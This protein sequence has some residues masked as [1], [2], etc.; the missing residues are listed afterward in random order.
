MTPVP[1]LA[2]NGPTAS[3]KTAVAV[4]VA[5]ALASEGIPAEIVNADSM[6]V[7]RG[8]NIGTAKPTQAERGGVPHHLIDIMDV[9]Q[10]ASVADFQQL[11]RAVIAE[12]S[13][14]GVVPIL[15]GG[16][17]LYVHAIVD[18]FRFPGTD[19]ELRA[20][21]EA[22]LAELGPAALHER[23][24]RLAPEAAAGILPGNGRR[25]V[26]ALEV[27]ELTGGFRSQLPEWSYAL[28]DVVQ[29]GLEVARDVLDARIEERVERMW[30]DGLV[31]EVVGL[32]DRGLRKGRTASR[33]IGYRQ[34]L[35]QL[36]GEL[37][38]A[39][40]KQQ[41][42]FGTRRLARKQL[43]WF[44]RDPRI[45]W[46]PAGPDAVQRIVAVVRGRVERIGG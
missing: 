40:A 42:V 10:D 17:A 45:E 21:L 6:L 31:A 38:E 2:L 29:V 19:P 15:A 24:I 11:A 41:T 20:R 39:Q 32:V 23:L 3:G 27:V 34:V 43:G 36:D 28:D 9:T 4:A 44:R 30:S 13:G 7:Y 46:L 26:R 37:T 12:C 16:S 22:E 14:R 18:D 25:I 8:M 1:V 35:A 33:A 5:H